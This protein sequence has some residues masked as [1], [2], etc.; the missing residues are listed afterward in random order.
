VPQKFVGVKEIAQVAAA[1]RDEENRRRRQNQNKE[2]DE[3][4]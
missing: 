3:R 4:L 1:G 2:R